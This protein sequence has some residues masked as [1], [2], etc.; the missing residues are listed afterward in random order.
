MFGLVLLSASASTVDYV[1]LTFQAN[2]HPPLATSP[3]RAHRWTATVSP[4]GQKSCT[5][6]DRFHYVKELNELFVHTRTFCS[7]L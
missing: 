5:T 2:K 4:T 3:Q 1:T 7:T 6:L